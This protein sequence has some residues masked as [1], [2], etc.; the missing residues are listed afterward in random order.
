MRLCSLPPVMSSLLT[1]GRKAVTKFKLSCPT[2]MTRQ[3]QN[4]AAAPNL[5][6]LSGETQREEA[7]R[8]INRD[9][10]GMNYYPSPNDTTYIGSDT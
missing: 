2:Q 4:E 8:N 9:M 3:S 1:G 10:L 6:E 7:S 5:W